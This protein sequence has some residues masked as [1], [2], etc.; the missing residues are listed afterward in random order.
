M[1]SINDRLKSFLLDILVREKE[2]QAE[3]WKH[4]KMLDLDCDDLYI[5]ITETS[6][7][8]EAW[9]LYQTKNPTKD[10][11]LYLM[12]GTSKS[13][14]AEACM[15]ERF[16]L[17]N[18]DLE[19]LVE[20]T[21][22]DKF[23]RQLLL[24]KPNNE[25]LTTI[26]THS[27][28]KEEAAT[29]LLK[30]PLDNYD[31]RDII[32]NSNLKRREALERLFQ[33]NPTNEDLSEII[34]YTDLGDL[35]ELVWNQFLSQNPGNEE[36]LYFVKDYSGRGRK[37]KEAAAL[38]IERDPDADA[39]AE[40]IVA[41]QFTDIALAKLR[42]LKP[43]PEE[44]EF[45][46][47]LKKRGMNEIAALCLS[48]NPNKEQLF[49]IL[50]N[51]DKKT[52]AALQ[53]IQL[54]LE[55]HELA[56]LIV[57]TSIEPVLELISKRVQ[58]DRSQVNEEELLQV[59]TQKIL[60]NPELLDVD[61]WHNGEKHCLGGWAITLNEASQKIEQEFGSEIAAGLLL[62]NYTHLF[63]S[64]KKTVLEALKKKSIA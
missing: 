33:Q 14:E 5:V 52:E 61:H 34:C 16:E 62:P 44:L 47:R 29:E 6:F 43:D 3:T 46:I 4:L 30:R 25:Q 41:D 57:Y 48:L 45:V 27:S 28:L 63:F 50:A 23:A 59:I 12:D 60:K 39:L 53:L 11:L 1:K 36:L 8:D 40:L 58:F 56:D 51:S 64:D 15:M 21:G 55:L 22:Q 49:E 24:Q 19:W 35:E 17:E 20:K 37:K 54:P 32:S 10:N 42:E 7:A 9:E 31:L 2:T 38:L 13:R 26:I 18:D